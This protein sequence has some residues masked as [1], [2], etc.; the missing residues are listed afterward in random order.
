MNIY[1]NIVY[2][3]LVCC[4]TLPF[5]FDVDP[6]LFKGEGSAGQGEGLITRRE[7]NNAGREINKLWIKSKSIY[8]YI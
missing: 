7:I 4:Q 1:M 2:G 6:S 8:I 5:Y 3:C